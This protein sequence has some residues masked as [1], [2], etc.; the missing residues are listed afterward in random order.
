MPWVASWW[1]RATN[2][3][4]TFVK[5][6][7]ARV[8]AVAADIDTMELVACVRAGM[9]V[10]AML[11]TPTERRGFLKEYDRQEEEA[12]RRAKQSSGG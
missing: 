10:D 4:A 2:R 12:Y 8:Q 5:Q 11:L 1:A 6:Y 7:D 9:S 3:T